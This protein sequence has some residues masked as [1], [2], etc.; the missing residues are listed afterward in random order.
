[1]EPLNKY[2]NGKIYKLWSLETDEIYV[3]STC[4]PLYK[5]MSKHKDSLKRGQK[6]NYKLYQEM[7]KKGEET[8]R[9]ELVEN[10]PC[11]TIDE[12]RK[13]EGYWIR[14]LK[15][16]LNMK[17][18]GRTP[19]D[20]RDE[21]KEEMKEYLKQ[22][23]KNNYEKLSKDQ[24]I[25]RENNKDYIKEWKKQHYE[26]NKGAIRAKHKE[27]R[28]KHRDVVL[29]KKKRY[30]HQNREKILQQMVEEVVCTIC[31]CTGLK[32]NIKRHERTKKHL[33]ALEQQSN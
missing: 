3:G 12:L 8:F 24:K 17:I 4:S 22:Y 10:F 27:Y 7:V 19:K 14:E 13:R 9:I 16:T 23:R 25:R 33:Q 2:Q 21:H 30:Y 32:T 18:A 11:T 20:Y 26:A 5:R 28:E 1:M 29:E 15:A 31:G 6:S